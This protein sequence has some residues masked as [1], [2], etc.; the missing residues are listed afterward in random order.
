MSHKISVSTRFG[1]VAAIAAV[2]FAAPF[3]AASAA[4]LPAAQELIDKYIEA[5]G[6]RAAVEGIES[7]VTKGVFA[8]V[9]MGMSAGYENYVQP[10]NVYNAVNLEGMGSVL[11]GIKDGVAWESHFMNGDSILEGDK[12]TDAER[13]AVIETLLE[14]EKWYSGAEVTGEE[15]VGEA[16]AYAVEMTSTAGEAS[17]IYFDK[18]S[19][20]IIQRDGIGPDGLSNTTVIGDYK[21]VGGVMVAHSIQI[22]GGMTIEITMES[23]EHNV[24]I[25]AEQFDMPAGIQL[26]LNPPEA[27]EASDEGSAS[28]EEDEGSAAKEQT[29]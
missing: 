18:E 20:L 9:D 16:T 11:T 17:T 8:L 22:Q 13:N 26:L 4:D 6:G 3:S 24:A 19:G 7:R 29:E 27:A 12:K 2:M 10:P 25:A 21:D 14:W 15:A 1:I 5:I 28:K 23:V